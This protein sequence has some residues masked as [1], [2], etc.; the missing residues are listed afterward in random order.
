MP[1]ET[2]SVTEE[3][4]KET[5]P[6]TDIEDIV[7]SRPDFEPH[8]WEL[9][10]KATNWMKA[11]LRPE[12]RRELDAEYAIKYAGELDI[13]RV[14]SR[15]TTLAAM[16]QWRAD[17]KPLDGA[18]LKTLLSQEYDTF[19][20]KLQIRENKKTVEKEFILCEL[21]QTTEK[22]FTDIAQKKLVSLIEEAAAKDWNIDLS[23]AKQLQ[24]ILDTLPNALDAAAELVSICLNP[25]GDEADYT[26]EWCAKNIST[27]RMALII[28]AQG[29][30]N[31]YRDFF[32]NGFRLFRKSKTR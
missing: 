5:S 13:L 32:S 10:S 29:E 15:K 12:V 21:P 17:Q 20:V 7:A 11:Q 30:V 1:D 28:I 24:L 23:T 19:P 9:I 14:E 31:K 27:Y 18:E 8:E 16:E 2:V 22:R 6:L 25:W 26:A 4:V 3:Q